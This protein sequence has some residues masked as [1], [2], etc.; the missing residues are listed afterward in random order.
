MKFKFLRFITLKCN[1]NNEFK[2]ALSFFFQVHRLRWACAIQPQD[3]PQLPQ[4]WVC[5]RHE[6]TSLHPLSL[7][8]WVSL[9]KISTLSLLGRRTGQCLLGATSR[10]MGTCWQSTLHTCLEHSRL[11]FYRLTSMSKAPHS[12]A[13]LMMLPRWLWI[14]E[15]QLQQLASPAYLSVS[16]VA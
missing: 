16:N 13:L 2:K 7:K 9:P 4:A 3:I 6:S 8:L 12:T 15:K 5:T 1:N 10:R 11:M 14:T